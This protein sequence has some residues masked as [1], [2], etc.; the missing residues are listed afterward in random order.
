MCGLCPE[1]MTKVFI[2]H[3]PSFRARHIECVH[4][5][6]DPEV[7]YGKVSKGKK[8]RCLETDQEMAEDD[9]FARLESSVE[10]HVL[11]DLETNEQ[12]FE[13]AC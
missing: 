12:K 1:T 7:G 3:H 5:D 9:D 11:P 10:V 8:N 4:P 2:S 6:I 13:N